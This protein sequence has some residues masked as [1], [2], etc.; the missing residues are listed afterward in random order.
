MAQRH[1]GAEALASE[2]QH[3]VGCVD[4]DDTVAPSDQLAREGAG[5][6]AE[7]EHGAHALRVAA[8]ELIEERGPPAWQGRRRSRRRPLP[9]ASTPRRASR[10]RVVRVRFEDLGLAGCE[11][12]IGEHAL[13]VK[14]RQVLKLRGRVVL[15]RCRWRAAACC[16]VLLRV[17]LVIPGGLT[18]RSRAPTRP[19]RFPRRRRC[20]LPYVEVPC[21]SFR[22]RSG[23]G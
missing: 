15:R 21:R 18:T 1:L 14:V 8:P 17:L 23:R 6:A 5:A 4:A 22:S 20:E 12:L 16:R 2:G 7:I 9:A 13:G 3:R 11:L 10:P 19:W